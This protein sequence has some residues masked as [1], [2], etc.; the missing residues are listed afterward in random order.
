MSS[1]LLEDDLLA[2]FL[3]YFPDSKTR[4]KILGYSVKGDTT[5]MKRVLLFVFTAAILTGLS[6]AQTSAESQTSGSVSQNSSVQADHSGAQAQSQTGAQAATQNTLSG[7]SGNQ[8]AQAT[9]S[10]QATSGSTVHATLVKP[11]DAR[12]NKPGD[13]VVART[14]E[15]MKSN[16]ETVIPK[17]SKIVGHVTEAKARTAGESQSTM[18]IAFDHAVLKDGREVPMN[19]SIQALAQAQQATAADFGEESLASG[20]PAMA[21][22]GGGMAT[23]RATGGAGGL[24]GGT[25]GA[26]GATSG[27]LVNTAGSVGHTAGGSANGATSSALSSSSHGVVGLQ[28]L[29]LSSVG[30]SSLAAD[31]AGATSTQGSLAQGSS[32][33]TSTTQNVHLDSGTQMILQVAGK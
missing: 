32:L 1:H 11:V 28:G 4:S 10:T 29:S 23:G 13:E 14:T 26:I 12:K 5:F 9:S 20:S 3:Q 24:V 7:K 33:I 25:G 16:G 6:F 31:A 27:T 2:G 15:N 17:G 8:S 22:G 21:A 19:A 18:G 30:T